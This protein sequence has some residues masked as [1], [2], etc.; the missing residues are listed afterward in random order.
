[1]GWTLTRLN[2]PHYLESD[3][4]KLLTRYLPSVDFHYGQLYHIV[5]NL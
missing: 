3:L 5:D 1:M 2:P 4:F